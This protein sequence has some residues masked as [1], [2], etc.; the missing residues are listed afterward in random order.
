MRACARPG[1][2]TMSDQQL[3]APRRRPAI[4]RGLSVNRH[5]HLKH[6]PARPPVASW[7]PRYRRFVITSDVLVTF[8]TA[9]IVG[10]L[11]SAEGAE[12]Y[13]DLVL[14]GLTVLAVL[15]SLAMNRAWHVIV[16]GQGAEEYVR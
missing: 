13:K 4:L 9:L 10:A 11:I 16:L 3:G 2:T 14:G 6:E 1:G 8:C 7:E 5:T 15:C 12:L